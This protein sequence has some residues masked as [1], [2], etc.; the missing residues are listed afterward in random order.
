MA[1]R[2]RKKENEE[3]VVER[4]KV[5]DVDASMQGSLLFRDPVNLRINGKFEGKLDTKGSLTIGEKADIEADIV[6]ENIVISGRV[7][8]NVLAS[9]RLSLTRTAHLVGDIRAPKVS[10]SEGAIFQGKCQMEEKGS[11]ISR[12]TME[13]TS[14]SVDELAKYLEVDS[15]SIVDWAKNSRIPAQK[16]GSSWKFDRTRVDA[17]IASEK[18]K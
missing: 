5:L 18:I 3:P 8:G 11:K 6:G 7:S 4:D 16:E 17:W 12:S 9:S 10:I 2:G 15:T 14:M 1:F 13:Q